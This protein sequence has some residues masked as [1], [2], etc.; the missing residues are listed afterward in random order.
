MVFVIIIRLTTVNIKHIMQSAHEMDDDD[1]N[2]RYFIKV[3]FGTVPVGSVHKR[4]IE[5]K[6]DLK[7][8][9]HFIFHRLFDNINC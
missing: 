4:S 1:A 2:N 5:I 3:D 9:S 6:N 7:A 8:S